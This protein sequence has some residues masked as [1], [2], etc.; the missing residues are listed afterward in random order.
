M[1][2]GLL[3]R[4]A[5]PIA[6]LIVMVAVG[7]VLRV[8]DLAAVARAPRAV[9]TGLVAQLVLL[10]LAAAA[11]AWAWRLPAPFAIGLVLVAS[12]PSAS[13]SNLLTVLARGNVGLAVSLT[14]IGAVATLLT[15]P[16]FV[17]LA[18]RLWDGAAYDL[19]LPVAQTL[20]RLFALVVAPLAAGMLLRHFAPRLATRLE[21]GFGVAGGI[22]LVVVVA[23]YAVANG[24]LLGG[25]IARLWLPVLSLSLAAVLAGLLSA[26]LAGLDRRDAI[27]L[28]MEVG[29]HNCM[30]A[31]LIAFTLM[32]STEVG[33]PALTYGVLMFVPA[34]GLVAL[35]R[36]HARG[37]G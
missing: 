5:L 24:A 17:D 14:A 1:D 3:V 20:G 27:T 10:P 37:R 9:A 2:A 25:A 8:A 16:L 36:L 7:L 13:V 21:R 4:I 34:L 11:I 32:Q 29:V 33:M 26:W 6:N 31:L 35:G 22:A 23:A 19:H 18:S 12:C 15:I 28:A 30:L